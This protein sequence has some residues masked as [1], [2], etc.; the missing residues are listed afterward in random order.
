MRIGLQ[1]RFSIMQTPSKPNRMA[2]SCNHHSPILPIMK[3]TPVLLLILDGFGYSEEIAN[4]A[5]AMAHT[6][7]WD[8]YWARYPHTLLKT[9]EQAVGLPAGQMGN[10][11]VGHLNIGAGRVVYQDFERINRAIETGEFT[12]NPVLA[13]AIQTAL[14]NQAAL[15]I[16]GLLSDGG[17][18]SHET[19]IHAMLRMA[20]K[21][22]LDKV[23]IHAFLDGRDTPP[24]SAEQYLRNLEA[25]CAAVGGGRIASIIG[26]YY[27]MDRDKRWPRVEAAYNLIICGQGKF[28]AN[29]ALAALE[30]AYARGESDEFVLATTVGAPVRVE[31]GDVI[32]HMNF[33][34]DRT[35]QLMR[36]ILDPGFAEFPRRYVP[37]LGGFYTLTQYNRD[38]PASHVA[39]PP[40]A[41]CNT[42]GEY[43]SKLGLTQLRIAE[44]EKYPHVTFFFNGGE[45]RIYP[46][47]DRILVP[48]PQVATY[49]LKPQM[50]AFEVTDR[51]VDAIRSRKYDA[52]I[53]NY[54]NADMVGHTGNLEAAIRAIEALDACLG[55]VVP[56]MLETGGEIIITADHGN[57]ECMYDPANQQA[58]TQHTTNLAPFVYIGRPAR[59]TKRG[60]LCDIAP[61]LL[62]IM[63]LPKPAEMTGQSIIVFK[64]VALAANAG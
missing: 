13:S 33:R 39:Y 62:A 11:E 12:T 23:Y 29:S 28:A 20:V 57:A 21:A 32:L 1:A 63:G 56:A 22:G 43:I 44:T 19:H 60:A 27:A 4:N 61:A 48:S 3:V 10:S 42:F 50:S 52:I 6:P 30:A 8:N 25:Q 64:E 31:D 7:H 36:A 55:R 38:D 45:E 26:R 16:F 34:A 5:I 58:H 47:E 37:S 46:G 41:I 35:R 59:L 17:V 14:A 51:L 53:C 9:S 18:H 15:H 49:D 2:Y 24:K 54:A 40:Q